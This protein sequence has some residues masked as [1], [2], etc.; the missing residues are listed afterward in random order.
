MENT[1]STTIINSNQGYDR[2]DDLKRFD[3]SKTG[4]KGL[5]DAGLTSIPRIFLH[6]PETLSDLKPVSQTGSKSIPVIDLS[7]FDSHRRTAVVDQVSS[8]ARDY[9]FFQIVNHG[10]SQEILDRTIAAVK[11]FHEQ[12]AEVRAGFYRREGGTGFSYMSNVDLYQSKAASWRDTMTV[13][14]GPADPRFKIEVPE[15]CRGAVA[16]WD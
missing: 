16:E 2:F 4:V 6:P 1:K 9:G 3:E 14:L 5:V 8:A 15:I 13:R 12:P 11:A 7:G 10:I